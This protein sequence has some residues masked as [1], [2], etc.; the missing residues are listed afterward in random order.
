MIAFLDFEASSLS[1]RSYPIEIGWVFADGT[2]E[3]HLI[4]PASKWTDW[5]V[6]AEAIHGI[7]RARLETEGLAVEAVAQRMVAALGDHRLYASAPS[8]DGRWLSALMRAAGL[9]RKTLTLEGTDLLLHEAARDILQPVVPEDDLDR[10]VQN[11]VSLAEMRRWETPA[12][13]ALAD[14]EGERQRWLEVQRVAQGAAEKLRA[15]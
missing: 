14:A 15:S 11:I 5:D 9:P 12:H 6:Q 7:P 2:G 8:W 3:G 13:R 10:T 4:R 1:D